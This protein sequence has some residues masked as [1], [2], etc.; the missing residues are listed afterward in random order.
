[1]TNITKVLLMILFLVVAINCGKKD[2]IKIYKVVPPPLVFDSVKYSL[3]DTTKTFQELKTQAYATKGIYDRM[4]IFDYLF[5]HDPKNFRTNAIGEFF[6]HF[7]GSQKTDWDGTREMDLIVAVLDQDQY[8]AIKENC[9]YYM[10][11]HYFAT[12]QLDSVIFYMDN[13]RTFFPESRLFNER[14]FVLVKKTSD[15]I[16]RI[17][18]DKTIK[19]PERL[20]KLG[21]AYWKLGTFD[22]KSPLWTFQR[23][24]K[25]YFETIENNYPD[26]AFNANAIYAVVEYEYGEGERIDD[27]TCGV[28]LKNKFE[29]LLTQY[30]KTTARDEILLRTVGYYFCKMIMSHDPDISYK[31]LLIADSIFILIHPEDL[32]D[33]DSRESYNRRESS[34][35]KYLKKYGKFDV[36][37]HSELYK[38]L[39]YGTENVRIDTSR[40]P[41][42]IKRKI[43][44]YLKRCDNF[45]SRAFK[46]EDLLGP[47]DAIKS[48]RRIIERAIVALIDVDD[49]ESLAAEYAANAKLFY[50]WEGMSDGPFE[51]GMYAEEYLNAHID[52]PFKPY[53]YIFI[54][55]RY[56][57]AHECIVK[58]DETKWKKYTSLRCSYYLKA[59]KN[60]PNLLVNLTAEDMDRESFLYIPVEKRP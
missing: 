30:P 12:A 35:V 36:D 51:E 16:K 8:L 55:H 28:Y 40:L 57:S 23:P 48:K 49:I 44:E 1:M 26:N 4:Q 37:F 58:N 15:E 11:Q 13:L 32:F 27:T 56:C 5:V 46:P 17:N 59:A 20:W 47:E 33:D 43:V 10:I 42:I 3:I 39:F 7:D 24:A 52:T 19:E 14:H 38:S 54:A 2:D 31:Y 45:Q 18:M 22:W 9:L 6:K 50:E 53:L 41:Y 60:C 21:Y 25:K 29:D 34:L